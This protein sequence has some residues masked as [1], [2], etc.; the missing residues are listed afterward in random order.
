LESCDEQLARFY[1][2]SEIAN[3]AVFPHRLASRLLPE[4]RVHLE[5]NLNE[6]TA[7]LTNYIERGRL[8][9]WYSWIVDVTRA[10]KPGPAAVAQ[11]DATMTLE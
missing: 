1:T 7:L 11:E 10:T 4:Q 3:S 2:P 8:D 9:D 6:E 5:D